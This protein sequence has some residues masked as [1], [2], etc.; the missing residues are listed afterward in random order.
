MAAPSN[1]G[2]VRSPGAF[3]PVDGYFNHPD[4]PETRYVW[5]WISYQAPDLVVEVRVG[6]ALQ[7]Y[8]SVEG[9]DLPAGSLAAALADPSSQPGLGPVETMLVTAPASGGGDVMRAVLDHATGDRSALRTAILDRIARD[10][11]DVARLMAGRYPGT[12][13]ISYIPALAWI[14]MLRVAD[15]DDDESLRAKVMADVRPWLSGEEALFGDRVSYAAIAGTMIFSAIAELP[16][17]GEDAQA[18]A[19]LAAEGVALG[20]AEVSPGNGEYASGW[21]DD[22]FLGT[23]AAVRAGDEDGLAA[24]VRLVLATAARLQQPDGL[25]HH[26][27]E[28]PVAWGRGNGFGALGL[29]DSRP[30]CRPTIRTASGSS[31]STAGIWRG[32]ARS[33]P[34]TGCGGRLSTCPAVIGAALEYYDLTQ[35]P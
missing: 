28:A 8:S 21:S 33:R 32:C 1:D 7:V 26:D 27:A 31:T 19:R 34:R 4:R 22:F 30:F 6:D 29:S 24:A 16:D 35:A 10:P 18:A 17:G 20:A 5:R 13:S 15:I 3:P 23:V 11:L 2:S 25:F 12:P 14:H 9:D